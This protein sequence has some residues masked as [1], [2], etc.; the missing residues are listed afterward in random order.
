MLGH[1]GDWSKGRRRKTEN[2]DRPCPVDEA[3]Y[4][5]SL[6]GSF[7]SVMLKIISTTAFRNRVY[8]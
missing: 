5:T 2:I 6:D 7:D 3:R 8:G 4:G 1:S